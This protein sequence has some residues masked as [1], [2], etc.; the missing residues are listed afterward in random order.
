VGGYAVVI[1]KPVYSVLYVLCQQVSRCT[2]RCRA[3]AAAGLDQT[4]LLNSYLNS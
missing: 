1:L 3:G 4:V 2:G